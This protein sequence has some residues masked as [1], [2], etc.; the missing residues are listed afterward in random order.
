MIYYYELII[1]LLLILR[2]Q[3]PLPVQSLLQPINNI[4]ATAASVKHRGVQPT[5]CM[6][7][8]PEPSRGA[9]VKVFPGGPTNSGE[10]LPRAA[11]LDDGVIGCHRCITSH[12][13]NAPASSDMPPT[14]LALP[15]MHTIHNFHPSPHPTHH[16]HD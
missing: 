10:T 8:E 15:R 2:Q 5:D 3:P 13:G 1:T 11:H 14:P 16:S 7:I 12:S 9:R 6:D 4:G